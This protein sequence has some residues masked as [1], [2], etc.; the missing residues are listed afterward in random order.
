MARLHNPHSS[1]QV[2]RPHHG[3]QRTAQMDQSPDA[4]SERFNFLDEAWLQVD[5]GVVVRVGGHCSSLERRHVRRA[6]LPAVGDMIHQGLPMAC[7]Y[8]GSGPE[9]LL[10]APV[11]GRIIDVNRHLIS[12]PEALW[13]DPCHQG[14]IARVQP[15]E[16][17]QDMLST[18]KRTVVLAS[19]SRRPDRELVHRLSYLG[20]RV[21]ANRF[22]DNLIPVIRDNQ[23]SVLVLDAQAGSA[24]VASLLKWFTFA[25]P[26]VKVVLVA[27]PG[28]AGEAANWAS[29]TVPT[30]LAP[31]HDT[32]LSDALHAAFMPVPRTVRKAPRPAGSLG[33]RTFRFSRG[34]DLWASLIVSGQVL[35]QYDD[36]PSA[37]S[38]I[39]SRNGCAL[40]TVLGAERIKHSE[41]IREVTRSVKTLIL[42]T[43]DAGNLPGSLLVH[44]PAAR[45]ASELASDKVIYMR[46]QPASLGF[47]Q[48]V[49]DPNTTRALAR[50]LFAEIGYA[51]GFVPARETEGLPARHIH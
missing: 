30:P 14:W 28:S 16:L 10:P 44:A 46:V 18:R 6:Q 22:L 2:V 37:L 31:F 29:H 32:T 34:W 13:Q 12:H 7:L 26:E 21:I 38:R 4:R 9:R 1:I 51:L 15:E 33:A 45:D 20:C 49:L 24:S 48:R 23:A 41:M 25:A 3:T 8:S 19:A 17:L 43:G 50:H 11:T 42:T 27:A 40:E 39:A 47:T 5:R 36:L 35:R